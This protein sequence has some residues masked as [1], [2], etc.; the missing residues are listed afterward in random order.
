MTG[1]R[2]NFSR[3]PE[4]GPRKGAQPPLLRAPE[5]PENRDAASLS[6]DV[7]GA[8]RVRKKNRRFAGTG[9]WWT[10]SYA[11][12]SQGMIWDLRGN[13]PW[14][15]ELQAMT[16]RRTGKTLFSGATYGRAHHQQREDKK[17]RLRQ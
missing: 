3:G 16:R 12:P 13:V 11:N 7:T 14:P 4:N 15:I 2:E 10:Q 1:P 17:R 9:W 8:T 6:A 5:R